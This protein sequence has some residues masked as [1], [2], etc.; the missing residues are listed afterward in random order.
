MQ[1]YTVCLALEVDCMILH[2][3]A[4]SAEKAAIKALHT[5][6]SLEDRVRLALVH[7]VE[8][9]LLTPQH[10]AFDGLLVA[11]VFPGTLHSEY[12]ITDIN[13]FPEEL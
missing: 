7:K 12:H 5:V 2:V 10:F 6:V 1:K 3:E 4:E 11:G 9:N 13:N 8:M